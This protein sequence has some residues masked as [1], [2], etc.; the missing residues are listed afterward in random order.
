MIKNI[1]FD[2][3]NVLLKWQPETVVA[4]FFPEE[5]VLTLTQAMFRSQHWRNL[6]LGKLTEAELIHIYHQE[7]RIDSDRLRQLMQAVKESLLPVD[8]S[9]ELLN[10]L[11]QSGYSLFS[12]TDNVHEIM[13]YLKLKYNFWDLFKGVVVSAEVGYLKPMKQIYQKLIDLYD[14]DPRKSV[15]IDD[16]LA[17]VEGAKSLGM[18]GI[19]FLSAQQFIT[20]L[21]KIFDSFG[22]ARV[23]FSNSHTC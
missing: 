5:L 6:N 3:G 8:H 12:L 14:L 16:L 15:F 13:A 21:N 20:E 4:R 9:L 1:I 2:V 11:Y 22:Q 23:L 7:L 18:Q 19:Q 10:N 17:N